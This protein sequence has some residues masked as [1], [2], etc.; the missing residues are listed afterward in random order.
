M[1]LVASSGLQAKYTPTEELTRRAPHQIISTG[2]SLNQQI[3]SS[4]LKPSDTAALF[5]INRSGR[6]FLS[7][8]IHATGA[9][10]TNTVILINVPDVI[11]DLGG[12]TI[13][14]ASTV[15]ATGGSAIKLTTGI[16]N[17]TIMN[18]TISASQHG[19]GFDT[20]ITTSNNT[21]IM[22]DNVR[23]VNSKTN[24]IYSYAANNFTM[25]C[26]ETVSGQRGLYLD[27]CKRGLIADSSFNGTSP[28]GSA[29]A[30]GISSRDSVGIEFNDV[31]TANNVSS[32]S[33]YGLQMVR[34][35]GFLFTNFDSTSNSGV[36][37]V[38]G[39]FLD[40]S[41]GNRFVTC[42]SNANSSSSTVAYGFYS[43]ATSHGNVFTEC[44]ADLNG[45]SASTSGAGFY[46]LTGNNNVWNKCSA[47]GNTGTSTAYGFY[48]QTGSGPVFKNCLANGNNSA[49]TAIGI[50]INTTAGG[51][52]QNCDSSSNLGTTVAAGINLGGTCTLATVEY[53]KMLANT[54]TSQFGFRDQA[55]DSTTFLRGNVAF[56][57]GNVYNGSSEVIS[58][59]TTANYLI[60]YT[61]TAD[62]MNPQFLIKEADIANM[63]AFEAASSTWFNFSIIQ[64][65]LST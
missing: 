8:D 16:R 1:A 10:S 12:K 53:N 62:S 17:V 11:L 5:T 52:I 60:T 41:S 29:I 51:V 63:N 33:C 64:N 31:N 35:S 26:I 2:I 19:N 22:I 43:I 54:G 36:T 4:S 38:A 6:Y 32:A 40:S 44:V 57:H 56:G 61:E 28:A 50:G 45:G 23:I 9:V 30:T 34:C 14:V 59:N 7:T 3:A 15:T 20:G 24:G 13:T 55:A 42:N 46:N 21:N 18:G 37:T 47:S 39:I 25:S 58:G 49:G 27:T 48:S 65:A